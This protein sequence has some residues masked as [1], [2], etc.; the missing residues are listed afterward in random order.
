[1]AELIRDTI[2]GHL[3]RLITK[4]RVLQYAEERDP[5]LWKQYIDRDQTKD[6]ALYGN[7]EGTTP[8]D[9][10]GKQDAD[11]ASPSSEGSSQTH[12][13]DADQQEYGQLSSTITGERVD[14]ENGRDTAMVTWYGEDDPEVLCGSIEIVSIVNRCH[15]S[16]LPSKSLRGLRDLTTYLLCLHWLGNLQRWYGNRCGRLWRQRSVSHP[17]SHTLRRGLGFRTYDLGANVSRIRHLPGANSLIC[18]LCY[19]AVFS[20]LDR[21]YWKSRLNYRR[22]E[23]WRYI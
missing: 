14:T 5:S 12:M 20:V 17:G 3:V 6:M 13:A 7:S 10:Q 19:V 18:Q 11:V 15:C 23:Y 21:I 22:S 8:E 16:G 1:M 4:G 9:T 2:F